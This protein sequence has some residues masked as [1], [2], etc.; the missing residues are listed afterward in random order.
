[1]RRTT[2]E[3]L[4]RE[5]LTRAFA[6]IY[7]DYVVPLQVTP[8]FMER[9][10]TSNDIELSC[11]PLWLNAEDEVVA[12]ALL[13][14]RGH[15]AWVGGFGVAPAERGRGL[16]GPLILE[17]IER[18][19]SAGAQ[20]LQ[21]EVLENNP[22]ARRVYQRAGFRT[23]REVAR[24]T[25]PEPCQGYGEEVPIGELPLRPAE[26][27]VWQRQASYA[28]DA[29]CQARRRGASWA[30]FRPTTRGCELLDGSSP[31]DVLEGPAWISNE[32]V[33]SEL[34]AELR[35]EGW[36]EGFRQLEMVR[37]V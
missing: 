27:L 23:V 36:V 11:S 5:E 24:L 29:S 32:D 15:R 1:M 6:L 4:S 35:Q 33:G 8:E 19:R 7:T 20:I 16:A 28:L 13:G 25:A 9:H 37:Q 31:Q 22:L 26:E 3:T 34:F 21:L 12:L 2:A 30:V 17:T 14:L 10:L 18:A